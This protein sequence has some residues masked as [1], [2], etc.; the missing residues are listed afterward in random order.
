[1]IN[2]YCPGNTWIH[3]TPAWIKL[4]VLAVG[5]TAVAFVTSPVALG[6]ALLLLAA[7]YAV[8]RPPL[9]QL[10][11]LVRLTGLLV[12]V[13][14]ACQWFFTTPAQ[15]L[16]V[17]AR[18]VILLGAANLLTWT[19]TARD[20]IAAVETILAPL[21]RLGLRPEQAGIAIFLALRFIPLLAEEGRRIREAQAARGVRTSFTYLVPLVIRVLRMADG[22]GEALEVRGGGRAPHGGRSR[23]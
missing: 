8:A 2:P 4:A 23:V 5:G 10:W 14:A 20:L 15:A 17:A 1:M 22:V 6:G 7:A 3:R 9:T 12:V 11:R 13:I 16:V 18:I 19:T 21:A